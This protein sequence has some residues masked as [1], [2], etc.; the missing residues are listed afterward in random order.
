M[1][2]LIQKDEWEVIVYV[3]QYYMRY[4]KFPTLRDIANKTGLEPVQVSE[5]LKNPTVQKSLENRGIDWRPVSSDILT[6]EQIA[7]IQ[8]L[9]DISDKRTIGDKLKSLGISRSKYQ[10]WKKNKAFMEAY[11]E[12]GEKLYGESL[13]QVH[14]S[15]IAEAVSGS[16]PHQKLMLAVSGRW[17]EKK[18]DEEMN[19]R[20]V[21]M[22][23]LE[24]IQTHVSDAETLQAIA[25]EFEGILN[26]E[27]PALT[28]AQAINED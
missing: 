8:V 4:G 20:Y 16:F 18:R 26:P 17:D 3:D 27:T 7:T 23:V 13:P 22:K 24:I 19:V 25:G 21:L 28:Q 15:I 5:A 9:L 14:Q 2:H 6:G 11:R 12:A 1:T 10:G